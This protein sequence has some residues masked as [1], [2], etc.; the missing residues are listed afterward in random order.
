LAYVGCNIVHAAIAMCLCLGSNGLIYGG[1][2]LSFI[3]LSPNYAGTLYSICN[4][5]SCIFLI[6]S[7]YFTGMMIEEESSFDTWRVVFLTS[8]GL[9][10]ASGLI[11]VLFV[12]AQVQEWNT[13]R[14][15]NTFVDEV[16][17]PLKR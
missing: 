6:A 12:P 9:Y 5:F 16:K 1:L 8:A 7:P 15:E 3:D 4:C 2:F 14:E 10:T 11:Y 13:I 17:L